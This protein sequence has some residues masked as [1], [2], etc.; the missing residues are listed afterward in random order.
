MT[1]TLTP[2]STMNLVDLLYNYS[3]WFAL[4]AL[5]LI[6]TGLVVL[7]SGNSVGWVPLLCGVISGA[8]LW[9]ISKH[10]RPDQRSGGGL[11]RPNGRAS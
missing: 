7:A 8:L 5:G 9:M 1:S 11:A 4:L 10:Q 2:I 3:L 6:I